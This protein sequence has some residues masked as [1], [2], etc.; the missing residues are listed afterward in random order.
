MAV[1]LE[2]TTDDKAV[3]KIISVTDSAIDWDA[4]YP[5]PLDLQDDDQTDEKESDLPTFTESGRELSPVERKKAHYQVHHDESKLR[6]KQDDMPT[7]FV[8]HHPYRASVARTMREI[9]AEMY[10]NTQ[11]GKGDKV[12]RDMFTAVFQRF[13]IGMEQGFGGERE[14]A[15]RINGRLSNDTVQALEDAEVFIELNA[16][17]MRVYNQDRNKVRKNHAEK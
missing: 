10:A 8:F 14:T 11:K 13:Y 5:D 7:L 9:A 16:A 17:F 12:E 15:P 4:S 2:K 1:K 3:L 6:F